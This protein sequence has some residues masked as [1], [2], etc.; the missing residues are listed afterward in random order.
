MITRHN[1]PVAASSRFQQRDAAGIRAAIDG[2]KEFQKTHSLERA[3]GAADDRGRAAFLMA[4][5]LDS[6]AT[7][8]WVFSEGATP[9]TDRLRQASRESLH[10]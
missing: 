6:S 9:S 1:Q 7:M 5:V 3:V 8:A 2:L 10:T 4:F